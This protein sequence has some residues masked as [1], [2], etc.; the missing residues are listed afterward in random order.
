VKVTESN[1]W[2]VYRYDTVIY[3]A[4][5]EIDSVK[6]YDGSGNIEMTKKYTYT[7][8]KITS[9]IEKGTN[10]NGAYERIRTFTYN[11]SGQLTAVAVN[12]TLGSQ[13]GGGPENISGITYT[14]GNITG[15]TI[16]MG[17]P[18]AVTIEY[19]LTSPNPYLGMNIDT[20]DPLTMFSANNVAKAYANASPGSPFFEMSY[21]HANG[22]VKT[23]EEGEIGDYSRVTTLTYTCK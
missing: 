10:G 8:G 21:T 4:N 12:Y 11:G 16:D 1:D 2:G 6:T 23:I 15:G 7:S 20:E 5:G 3:K 17:F 14:G 19:D 18:V 13:N 22:R 9:V